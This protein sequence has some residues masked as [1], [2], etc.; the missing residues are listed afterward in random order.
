MKI[1][2]D[3]NVPAAEDFLAG[4][5]ELERV[6]GRSLSAEQ[7]QDADALVLR[8]VTQVNEALL[9]G[10]SVKFVGSCTIGTDHMD[11]AY[12]NARG[13]SYT[14]APGCNA[15]SVV[16]YV[17]AA[18]AAIDCDWRGKRLGIIGL[19][20]VGS[21]LY[22][23][24]EQLGIEC[25]GYDPLLPQDTYTILSSLEEVLSC[26]IISMHTPLTLSGPYPSYHLLG[27][28]ELS[29]LPPATVLINAGRGD[30]IDNQALL[31]CQKNGSALE[32][33]LDVWEREPNIEQALLPY[34]R[35]A[36][37]HIA[38][39]S[40]DGKLKGTQMVAEALCETFSLSLPELGPQNEGAV[41][42]LSIS[43]DCPDSMTA[44]Q[45]ALLG[46]YDVRLD[47]ERFREAQKTRA[48]DFATAFD[49]MR[50][51]YPKRLECRHFSVDDS[52]AVLLSQN[53]KQLLG[54]NLA[55]LGYSLSMRRV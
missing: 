24:A 52:A 27:Q 48:H 51:N 37:P 11:L 4:V 2:V 10:S 6:S 45:E 54:R 21:A 19:G 39:Y 5:G 9:G 22:R 55:A 13:I 8:S 47:D 25:V 33:I 49:E 30:C 40:Y 16:E 53:E 42:A 23:R 12:L 36:T 26:D 1:I 7:V 29:V 28:K 38:G 50:K 20:N 46:V 43:K 35:I 32:L 18:L 44:L 17:F 31:A 15:N 3:E 41:T 34:V 14:N